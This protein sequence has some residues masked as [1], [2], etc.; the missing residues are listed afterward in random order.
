[1]LKYCNVVSITQIPEQIVSNTISVSTFLFLIESLLAAEE[2]AYNEETSE[3][4]NFNSN[5]D[6]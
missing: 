4:K 3:L 6:F 2:A 5:R 1:M